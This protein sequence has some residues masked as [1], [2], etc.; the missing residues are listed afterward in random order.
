MK[1]LYWLPLMTALGISLA[2]CSMM[3]SPDTESSGTNGTM[4]RA[5]AGTTAPARQSSGKCAPDKVGDAAGQGSD[6]SD[7]S[8]SGSR[9]GGANPTPPDSSSSND[10]NASSTAPPHN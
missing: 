5:D 7:T 1:N 2:G 10:P 4:H 9:S 8:T 6:C 3:K